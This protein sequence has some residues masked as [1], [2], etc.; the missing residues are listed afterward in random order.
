[1]NNHNEKKQ[2]EVLQDADPKDKVLWAVQSFGREEETCQP[3]VD[4]ET[5]ELYVRTMSATGLVSE[6]VEWPGTAAQFTR[7]LVSDVHE[8]LTQSEHQLASMRQ[9]M[10]AAKK[11]LEESTREL[12]ALKESLCAKAELESQDEDADEPHESAR[13]QRRNQRRAAHAQAL[14]NALTN[15][16]TEIHAYGKLSPGQEGMAR[17]VLVQYRREASAR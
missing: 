12:K 10:E 15:V 16:I 2:V 13:A 4:F 14:A 1:M 8:Q 5:A 17:Q 3:A 6:V 9:E 7:L 11:A